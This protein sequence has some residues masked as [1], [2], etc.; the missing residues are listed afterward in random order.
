MIVK[1]GLLHQGR[2]AGQ[3]L[4]E[5]PCDCANKPPGAISHGVSY[6]SEFYL[7]QSSYRR[8]N[9]SVGLLHVI[10]STSPGGIILR[11]LYINKLGDS[12]YVFC[13]VI[14][15]LANLQCVRYIIQ[16]APVTC[17]KQKRNISLKASH[18]YIPDYN[19]GSYLEKLH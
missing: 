17:N 6:F 16:R 9:N 19:Y 13:K 18:I 1:R 11:V 10:D 8:Y 7:A 12:S 2:N 3:G 15:L 5:S 4:L 14:K